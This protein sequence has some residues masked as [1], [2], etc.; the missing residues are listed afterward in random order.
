M[1]DLVGV[2]AAKVL[3]VWPLVADLVT[4]ALDRSNGAMEAEDVLKALLR[5]DM[6]LWVVEGGG[7]PQAVG[8]TEIVDHPRKRACFIYLVAGIRREE[9]LHYENV[10]AAWA[11][12]QRC[13]FIETYAR[14]G[15]KRVLKDWIPAA[16]VLHKEL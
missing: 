2:P 13:D 8:V 7:K 11:R 4:K 5:R 10:L 9:W 16:V 3:G 6:Q 15:W 12:E 1:T 14:V